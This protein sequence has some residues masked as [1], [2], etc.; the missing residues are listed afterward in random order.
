MGVLVLVSSLMLFFSITTSREPHCSK[1]HYEEQLL[2][3][4]IRGEIKEEHLVAEVDKI[5]TEAE[6]DKQALKGK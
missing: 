4:I 5:K 6:A 3:K 1:F 2:E